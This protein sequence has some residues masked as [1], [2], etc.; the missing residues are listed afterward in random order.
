MG[1]GTVIGL[2]LAALQLGWRL[3]VLEIKDPK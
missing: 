1:A 2:R 3:P